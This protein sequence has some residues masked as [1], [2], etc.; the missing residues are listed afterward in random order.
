[1][2]AP[3]NTF[4]DSRVSTKASIQLNL[5]EFISSYDDTVSKQP[6]IGSPALYV[7]N[8]KASG[9]I[10]KILTASENWAYASGRYRPVNCL[11]LIKSRQIT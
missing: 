8:L 7:S 10:N 5:G 11:W 6:Y 1:M 9:I 4:S 2:P 3:L